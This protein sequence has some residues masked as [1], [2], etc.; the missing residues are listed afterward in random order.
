MT[1][2]PHAMTARSTRFANQLRGRFGL[3]VHY[4]DERLSSAE[5]ADN[6]RAAGHD[7]R[8]A[9]RHL[10]AV[11]AQLILQDYFNGTATRASRHTFIDPEYP[12]ERA[13]T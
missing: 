13:T 3:T 5:A 7:T 8:S 6:L 12:D 1:G 9:R 10:D 4:A 11:A 2:A